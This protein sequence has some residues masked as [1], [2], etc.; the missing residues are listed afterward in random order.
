MRPQLLQK[1]QYKV[2]SEKE[3]FARLFF[4]FKGFEE[5]TSLFLKREIIP[6]RVR[7]PFRYDYILNHK[8]FVSV[9]GF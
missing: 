3:P 6:K 5:R 4:T 9:N 1:N 2:K 7:L 8:F